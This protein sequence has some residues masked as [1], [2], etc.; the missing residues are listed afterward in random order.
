VAYGGLGTLSPAPDYRGDWSSPEAALTRNNAPTSQIVESEA[1]RIA[2][3]EITMNPKQLFVAVPAA[4]LVLGS[5]A[6]NAGGTINE[7]GAIACVNDKWK[8]SEPDKGHKLVDL[9]QRCVLI[10]DDAAAPK[11]TEECV[12]N[13][14]Y[15]P[16]Q[17]WKGTGTCTNIYKGGDK[18]SLAW[19]E[20][21]HLK[22]YT[23][24]YTGGTGKYQGA[25]GGGT[26]MYE[27]LTDTLF[28]GRYKGKLELQ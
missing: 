9:A 28:G 16:D 5:G 1:D 22:E 13:Y 18:A 12:G 8:E 27:S 14:E 23:Y 10:P 17:S 26:Y 15:M 25:S 4:I 2:R 19:E 20:G 6:A 24:K 11:A 3:E 21:S 7:A